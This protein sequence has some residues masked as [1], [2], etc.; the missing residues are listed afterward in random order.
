MLRKSAEENLWHL[1]LDMWS[2]PRKNKRGKDPTTK[3]EEATQGQCISN[4][5]IVQLSGLPLS[6]PTHLPTA[7]VSAKARETDDAYDSSSFILL[8]R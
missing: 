4:P 8:F 7:F 5:L 2:T 1:S 6:Q 3:I